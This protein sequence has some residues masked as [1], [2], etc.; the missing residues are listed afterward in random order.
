MSAIAW[1]D[2]TWLEAEAADLT[3]PRSAVDP[4][5]LVRTRCT[6]FIVQAQRRFIVQGSAASYVART[7]P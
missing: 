6:R 3:T 4:G 7:L 2:W 1:P 5:Y